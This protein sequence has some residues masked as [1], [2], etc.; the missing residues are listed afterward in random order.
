MNGITDDV[1]YH[2]NNPNEVDINGNPYD[3]QR[4]IDV[5]VD[6]A[7]KIKRKHEAG[8]GIRRISKK[9]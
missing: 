9:R 1:I 7:R 2:T 3:G 5:L 6:L 4:M 8:F